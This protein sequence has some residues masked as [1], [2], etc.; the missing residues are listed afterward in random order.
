MAA[1]RRGL[2]THQA[3]LSPIQQFPLDLLAALQSDGRRQRQGKVDVVTGGLVLGADDLYFYGIF[4]L[5]RL[6]YSLEYQYVKT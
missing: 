5:H 6:E 1:G 3:Q 4:C 2:R